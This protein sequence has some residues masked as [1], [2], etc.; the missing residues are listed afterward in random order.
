MT[1]TDIAIRNSQTE[2]SPWQ[3]FADD[4]LA[5]AI[6]GELLT[7]RKG[8]WCIGEAKEPVADDARFLCNMEEIWTGWVR[9]FDKKP[10]EHRIGRLI[11]FPRKITR[12]ELGHTD[13]NLWETDLA[14]VPRDPWAPTDR[15]VMRAIDRDE[16]VTF[17]TS[18]VGGRFALAKLCSSFARS[19]KKHE[20]KYPVV[21]LGS[22]T[23]EHESYGEIAKPNFK[24]VDWAYWD[25]DHAGSRPMALAPAEEI[26][27]ELDDA[28][29]F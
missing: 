26:A 24:I 5:A 21:V 2:T 20:M 7:F 28:I 16:L 17:S 4:N 1:S 3:A 18:S 25:D 29:P 12:E 11:D 23:Y 27:H 15:L 6:A 13:K 10:V 19:R 22:E 9:W 8:K 14:G